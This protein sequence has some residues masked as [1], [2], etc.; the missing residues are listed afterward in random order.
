MRSRI[1]KVPILLAV[2]AGVCGGFASA[3]G[4]AQPVVKACVGTTFSGAAAALPPGGVGQAVRGFAQDPTTRPGI[5]DGIQALQAG[6]VPDDVVV[7][8]CN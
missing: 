5:G 6:L 7:N 4:A 2:A 1:R 8:T 3:A